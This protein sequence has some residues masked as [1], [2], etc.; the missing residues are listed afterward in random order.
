MT[1]ENIETKHISTFNF[2]SSQAERK[3]NLYLIIIQ[4]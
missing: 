2:V 1:A 4:H 3:K